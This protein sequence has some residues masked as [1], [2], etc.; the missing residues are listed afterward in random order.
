MT[1]PLTI[2]PIRTGLL[3]VFGFL[4]L[5]QAGHSAGPVTV[6]KGVLSPD[7]DLVLSSPG[8]N[9]KVSVGVTAAGRLSY[10]VSE[11]GV[12]VLAPSSLGLTVDGVDLGQGARITGLPVT[13][14]I[15]ETYPINGSH[16]TARN[17]GV[18]ADFPIETAGKKFGLIIR[19]YDD[20]VAV[21]YVLPDGSKRI[22]SE[23][24]SWNL[25]E[26]TTKVAWIRGDYEAESHATP[27]EKVP[28]GVQ[29]MAPL[30]A[31]VP[32]HVLV[33]SEAD[34]ENF[35]DMT[36]VRKGCVLSSYFGPNP[37]GWE[38]ARRKDETN[39]HIPD[40]SYLGKPA[41]PWRYTVVGKNYNEAINSDLITNLCPPPRM[42]FSWVK[43]GRSLWA[44]WS[45]DTPPYAEL[46][47]WYDAAAEIGWDYF[48]V[49]WGWDTW[50][51]PGKDAFACMKDLAD[52]GNA[53]GIKTIAWVHSNKI[54][55]AKGRRAY[56]EKIKAC[57][58]SGIKIDF[59]SAATADYMQWYL[60][61]MQDCAE[62]GL[63]VNFHGSVKPTGLQRTYPNDITREAV[64]GNEWHMTK[65]GRVASSFQ[66]VTM[67]FT[68]PL[69]G[70][71]D[72]T[73]VMLNP[74]ELKTAKF[75]WPHEMAQAVV[76]QSSV[77]HFADHYKFIIGS[78]MEDFLK[79]MPVTWDETIV[80][81]A[82]EMG[83][84][85]AYA[86]RKGDTWW[87]GVM[88]G[89][90][91]REITLKLDFL[92]KPTHGSFLYD[93]ADQQAAVDRREQ[94]V[95]PGDAITLKLRP[96]GGFTAR[97]GPS[98]ARGPIHPGQ[99]NGAKVGVPSQGGNDP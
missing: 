55:D 63:L 90:T 46:P 58:L 68:R 50:K 72:M 49:D 87:I 4:L 41:S 37:K 45:V 14:A 67:P 39:P 27:L 12:Q 93:V 43:P 15:N 5:Q 69:C 32:G 78:P 79:E 21:R 30:S 16:T 35:P 18:E 88:N 95:K 22:D 23:S 92:K 60:G 96:E 2:R 80:L 52:Y 62:L 57:G 47:K 61:A 1:A 28:E 36:M 38:I 89:G 51:L 48:L 65:Y 3:S 7:R 17:H 10:T 71:A 44:W 97:L 59:Q 86:R 99:S 91:D 13:R 84:V 94:E 24:T 81:P 85:V 82:T 34:C 73:P 98:Q 75:T 40:G 6:E 56:L 83:E 66:D 26:K 54:Q 31:E 8:Q 19:A 53:K 29:L 11:N 33:M 25:P 70:S 42:D 77:T 64:R 74:H 20:G 76:F 9:L